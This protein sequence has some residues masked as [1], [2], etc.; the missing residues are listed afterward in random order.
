MPCWRFAFLVHSSSL[1]HVLASRCHA[2]GKRTART[3]ERASCILF[4]FERRPAMPSVSSLTVLSHR[5]AAGVM[6]VGYLAV[7][8]LW[9]VAVIRKIAAATQ[10]LAALLCFGSGAIYIGRTEFMPYHAQ[11]VGMP[12]TAITPKLQALVLGMMT[13]M[14]GAYLAS[15]ATLLWLL[16]PLLRAERW[17][18]Y[19]VLSNAILL[20]LPVLYITVS[21]RGISP[22]AQTPVA[23]TAIL[24]SVLVLGG[25]LQLISSRSDSAG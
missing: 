2:R 5:T 15:G 20:W 4:C 22:S 19:A 8:L 9:R 23:P 18:A 24:L 17:A 16:K 6:Q 21:L 14:G 3:G 25:V 1:E 10:V 12:W 11:V 13:V 7:S